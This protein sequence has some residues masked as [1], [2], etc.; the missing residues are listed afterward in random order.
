[1]PSRLQKEY[2]FSPHGCSGIDLVS[3][4]MAARMVECRILK[5]PLS[6]VHLI[7]TQK[8]TWIFLIRLRLSPVSY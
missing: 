7:V 6:P 4:A 5:V 8:D 2:Q 1:M 3:N